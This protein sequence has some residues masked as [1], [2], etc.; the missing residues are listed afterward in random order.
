M[1]TTQQA[2]SVSFAQFSALQRT[3]VLPTPQQLLDFQVETL[4]AKGLAKYDDADRL[5]NDLPSGPFI[6]VP[7]QPKLDKDMLKHLMS[8]IIVN[9]K[10]GVTGLNLNYI[11]DEVKLPNGAHLMVDVEDGNARRNL[12]PSRNLKA[13]LVEDRQPYNI[14]RGIV[15]TVLFP[16]TLTQHYLDL[17]ASRYGF[18]LWSH[19]YLSVG[20]PKLCADWDDDAHTEWGAPSCGGVIGV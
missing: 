11:K 3:P 18:G 19:L 5:R 20:Q 9:G 16:E 4:V 17:V 7:V 10:S 15:Y 14:W 12:S 13:I 1:I 2:T 8:L 6:F